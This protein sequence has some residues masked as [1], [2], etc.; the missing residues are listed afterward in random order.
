MEPCLR[1]SCGGRGRSGAT[2]NLLLRGPDKD[3]AGIHTARKGKDEKDVCRRLPRR[4]VIRRA[5][6]ASLAPRWC[7]RQHQLH[8]TEAASGRRL[9][10]LSQSD[11]RPSMPQDSLRAH[12][13]TRR[14]SDSWPV[15]MHGRSVR[16]RSLSLSS[17][18]SSTGQDGENGSLKVDSCWK[19]NNHDSTVTGSKALAEG[20]L[21]NHLP[22]PPPP[23][24]FSSSV[25][26][27]ESRA[28]GEGHVTLFARGVR[29]RR[30]AA[31]LTR[32]ASSSRLTA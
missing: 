19:S 26:L 20:N 23:F 9:G 25:V 21:W 17:G 31:G 24:F 15:E 30:R 10:K 6:L 27:V 13:E 18:A 16:I 12:G 11:W 2:A 7:V 8:H 14:A 1:S 3:N 29:I 4:Q 5:A 32:T 28:V 22:P